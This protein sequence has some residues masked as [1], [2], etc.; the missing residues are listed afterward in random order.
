MKTQ[1]KDIIQ[2]LKTLNS[3]FLLE[4]KEREF[5]EKNSLELSEDFYSNVMKNLPSKESKIISIAPIKRTKIIQIAASIIILVTVSFLTYTFMAPGNSINTNENQLQQLL[6]QT[7]SQEI[8][9]YLLE[10]GLPTDEEFLINY[11]N[12]SFDITNLN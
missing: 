5:N 2:E 8:D 3:T 1:Q 10:N 11:V 6:S 4:N 7:S 12:T 9:D